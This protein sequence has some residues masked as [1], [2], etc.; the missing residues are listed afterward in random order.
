MNG[1]GLDIILKAIPRVS[2]ISFSVTQQFDLP[3]GKV[4]TESCL[5][6]NTDHHWICLYIPQDE[7]MALEY[8]DPLGEPPTPTMNRFISTQERRY[9]FNR[10][11][12]VHFVL[13]SAYISLF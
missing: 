8:F 10:V 2:Q 6:V 5:I 12:V 7:K 4:L 3:S 9:I 11:K 13:I 1:Y